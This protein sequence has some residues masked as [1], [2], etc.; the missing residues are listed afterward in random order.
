MMAISLVLS[1]INLRKILSMFVA[2]IFFWFILSEQTSL[3]FIVV[4]I[5][6]IIVIQLIDRKL[7]PKTCISP[8]WHWLSF[9]IQLLKEMLLS[10]FNVMKFIWL[11]PKAISPC[12]G[13]IDVSSKTPLNQ[14]IYANCITLTPGTMTMDIKDNKILVHALTTEALQE[15][16]QA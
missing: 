11:K 4:A 1:V 6:S 14:V 7:F 12:R 16:E 2:L 9:F 10:T 3:F 5:F 15:L 8:S 13:W